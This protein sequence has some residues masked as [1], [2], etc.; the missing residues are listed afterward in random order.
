[1]EGPARRV[2]H[3]GTEQA[4]EEGFIQP[5]LRVLGWELNYQTSLRG[6]KPDYALF[7]SA[8]AYDAALR[9][10]PRTPESGSTRRSS[11]TLRLGTD[12]WTGRR[13]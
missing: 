10:G 12:R 13:W 8:E 3:Y 1:V 9:A 6:R 11:P 7:L 2:E 5:V 4:L